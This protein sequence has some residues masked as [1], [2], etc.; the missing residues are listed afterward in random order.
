MI[1]DRASKDVSQ[2]L[3]LHCVRKMKAGCLSVPRHP[4]NELILPPGLCLRHMEIGL[5]FELFSIDV[6]TTD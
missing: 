3:K 6:L 2:S 4:I 1:D 5:S